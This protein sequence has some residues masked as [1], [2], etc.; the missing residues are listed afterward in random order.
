MLSMD[1]PTLP[2]AD[3]GPG[4]AP[5]AAK[6]L[7]P[8]RLVRL[9]ARA[10]PKQ[11]PPASRRGQFSL[12]I[13]RGDGERVMRLNFPRR[14][15]VLA[16]LALAV[17]VSVTGALVG[18]WVKLRELTR[19]AVTF[20]DQINQQR[21][22]IEAFNRRVGELR[23]EMAS[24]RDIHARIWE[25]FGPE[26]ARAKGDRGIGGG[27]TS[28]DG[29]PPRVSP[30]EDL[31]RLGE[32]VKEQTDSLKALEKLMS[33]AGKVLTALPTRWPVRGGVNSEFGNRQSPWTT[34]REF[35]SGLDIRADRNTPVHAPAAGT[36][37]HAGPA[38]DYGTTIILDHGQ[39]IRTLYGHLQ[40][41]NVQHGQQVER[42]AVIGYTGNTGR[43]SG[44]HLHY[45]II[46]KGQAVNP[47]AYLW[48]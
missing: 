17:V 5:K 42:G 32:S 36:V 27:T 4:P 12:L 24:W 20:Q 19:E 9:A 33:R 8:S 38:Q 46:V 41:V 45:E 44:P 1:T 18:D 10:Y 43:S 7:T 28:A 14:S 35:H 40:K 11:R 16:S 15:V 26:L 47:R 6:P 21:A 3:A 25:P 39:N 37:V 2:A 22:T 29:T 34:E 31:N 13:V 30:L 48:E 23:Q